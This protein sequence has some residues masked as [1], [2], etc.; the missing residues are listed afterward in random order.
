MRHIEHEL[1]G[2]KCAARRDCM[3]KLGGGEK[4]G[5]RVYRHIQ[6]V[7]SGAREIPTLKENYNITATN[8]GKSNA[9]QDFHKSVFQPTEEEMLNLEEDVG[10][11]DI[12]VQRLSRSSQAL[13]TR[14]L[15]C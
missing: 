9:L 6:S 11:I 13:E 4:D 5:K 15:E 7:T 14:M 3:R 12:S 8:E 10:D 1:V 2:E